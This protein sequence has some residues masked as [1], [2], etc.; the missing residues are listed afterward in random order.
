MGGEQHRFYFAPGVRVVQRDE[1]C[2]QFGVDST[3][4]GIIETARPDALAAGLHQLPRVFS[5][6]DFSM[7]SRYAD[8]SQS[9]AHSLFDD[10]LAYG[11]IRSAAPK[12]VIVFGTSPLATMLRN[13]LAEAN[14]LVRSPL[15]GEPEETYLS[16]QNA[17]EN[18]IPLV[19]VDKLAETT[20]LS[21][22]LLSLARTWIP[23]SLIDATSVVGPI[24]LDGVGPCPLCMELHRT[25]RDPT[26]HAAAQGLR[27]STTQP[28]HTRHHFPTAA[29]HIAIA[30]VIVVLETL[31]GLSP[32]PGALPHRLHP[33]QLYELD[34]YARPQQR[35]IDNHPR[36][37]ECFMHTGGQ[38]PISPV[39]TVGLSSDL[40]H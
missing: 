14:F 11:I 27:H 6:E 21:P 9:A 26:W 5:R 31:Y 8:L 10:L 30:Q 19:I 34:P 13:S 25:D 32:P 3:R 18:N 29:A 24:H 36:C 22:M 1:H 33:G 7:T 15:P 38:Y 28:L 17:K 4:V 23:V 39:Q 2:L 16:M 40:F 12:P 37:P 35:I 20:G